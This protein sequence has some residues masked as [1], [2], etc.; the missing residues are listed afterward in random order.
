[1]D[2]TIPDQYRDEV[3]EGKA[4]TFTVTGKLDTFAGVISAI[5]PAADAVT[6][7]LKIRAV[8]KNDDHKLVAG[9]FTHVLLAFGSNK[10]ALMIPSQGIIPTDRDKEV[11]VIKNGKAKMTVVTIGARTNDKVEIVQ[12]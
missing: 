9:S 5:E 4:I 1:M 10:K 6:R 12:G 8:V 2:F 3:K 7:T 11:A